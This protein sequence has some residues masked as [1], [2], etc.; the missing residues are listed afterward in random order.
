MGGAAAFHSS[1]P[2]VTAALH[3]SQHPVH[4][5]HPSGLRLC[6]MCRSVFGQVGMLHSNIEE[7]LESIVNKVKDFTNTQVCAGHPEASRGV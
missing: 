7:D 1:L 4:A 2:L 5:I 3:P 6:S